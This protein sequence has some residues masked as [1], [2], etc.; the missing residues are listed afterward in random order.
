MIK[1]FLQNNYIQNLVGFVISLYIKI[2]FHTS[3]WYVRNNK[4]LEN[5]IEKI[6]K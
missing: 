6:Q 2:C 3:L 1:K 5:H 4:E